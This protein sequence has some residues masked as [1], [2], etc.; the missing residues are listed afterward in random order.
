MLLK[1][2]TL[3]SLILI[4]VASA[5]FDHGHKEWTTLLKET[6]VLKGKQGLVNYKKVIAKKTLL[7]SYLLKLSNVK[8]DEFNKWSSNKRLSFLINAYNAFTFKLIIDNYPTKSIRKIRRPWKKRF[9]KLFGKDTHLDNIEHD[10]IRKKYNEPRIHFAVVCASIGCPSILP[11]AFTFD[12]LD[13]QLENATKNFL[14]DTN[15]NRYNKDKKRW[16]LSKIFK[17]YGKDFKEYGDLRNYVAKYIIT[18]SKE[19][20]RVL[21]EDYSIDYLD[22]DWSLNELK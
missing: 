20:N 6:V 9:F 17:W 15:K 12:K 19:R 8:E 21:I 3:I 11:V 14:S 18:D 5:N 2:T 1:L 13:K 4:S 16:E 7:D 22:Y 10:I